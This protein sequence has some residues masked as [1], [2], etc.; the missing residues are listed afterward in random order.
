MKVNIHEAKTHLSEYLLK[1]AA[2]EE[3]VISKYGQPIAKLVPYKS[4]NSYKFGSL[5]HKIHIG[6]DFDTPEE[7]QQ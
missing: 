3:I 2:G 4:D 5:K 1:V 6:A 7:V